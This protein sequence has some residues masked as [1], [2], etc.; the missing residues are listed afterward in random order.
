MARVRQES[1]KRKSEETREEK[2]EQR[3]AVRKKGCRRAK[4][5]YSRET[6]CLSNDL[7]FQRVDK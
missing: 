1:Q 5:S 2:K 7:W 3:K 4:I 6:V